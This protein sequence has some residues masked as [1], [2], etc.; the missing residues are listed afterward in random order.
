MPTITS[1]VPALI[2]AERG[3]QIHTGEQP[4]SFLDASIRIQILQLPFVLDLDRP[5][6]LDLVPRERVVDRVPDLSPRPSIRAWQQ[7]GR[8]YR[9]RWASISA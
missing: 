1:R 4:V 7:P 9:L 6:N 8:R 3:K 5:R 2:L